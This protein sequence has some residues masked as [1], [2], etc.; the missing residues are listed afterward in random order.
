[1]QPGL[2]SR[3]MLA[4]LF[5]MFTPVTDRLIYQFYRPIIEWVPR[6]GRMPVVPAAGFLL[7]D[8][9]LVGLIIW[10]WR[11]GRRWSPFAVT[12]LLLLPYHYSVLYFYQYDFWKAFC[13]WFVGI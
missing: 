7:A 10:D 4:T 12:L 6:I 9:I 13:A 1:K 11:S 8:L 3:Y 2:H 5:P